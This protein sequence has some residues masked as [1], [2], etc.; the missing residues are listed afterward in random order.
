MR[1]LRLA[2]GLAALSLSM[3]PVALA[4]GDP[5]SDVLPTADVYFP[6][7]A[8]APGPKDALASAVARVYAHGDRIKVAVI[9]RAAD[10]GA[11]PSLFDQPA[12]YAHFLGQELAGL[13]AGPLLIVQPRGFGI[14]D[15][16]RSTAAAKAVLK[17]LSVDRGSPDSL[18]ESA[19]TAVQKL[20]AAGAL[21]SPDVRAPYVYPDPPTAH[22]GKRVTLTYRVLDD[23]ERASATI[24]VTAGKRTLARLEQRNVSAVYTKQQRIRWQVPADV[25]R[26]GVKL[27][28]AVVDAAGNK[29]APVCVRVKVAA[30]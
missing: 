17:G 15:A 14:Y 30:R 27:C 6:L 12:T 3:A 13:Y 9:A 29:A 4:D 1:G 16:G 18:T 7:Q 20:E 5:A 22:P 28:V 26:Q 11:L 19:A 10:M 25:P 2:L 24:T 8:P 23:S 21:T